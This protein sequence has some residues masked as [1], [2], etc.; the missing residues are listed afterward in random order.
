VSQSKGSDAKLAALMSALA[1]HTESLSDAEVIEDA[2]AAGVDVN[3]EAERV[4]KILSDGMVRAKRARLEQARAAHSVATRAIQGRATRL[5]GTAAARRTM[6]IE[7]LRRAPE[8]RGAIVTL[9]HREFES[10]SD[11]DVESALRQLAALG[12]LDDSPKKDQ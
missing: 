6:L 1:D 9:Q 2:A 7:F 3:A 12:L 10:F 4:R 8:M 11:S 5:P